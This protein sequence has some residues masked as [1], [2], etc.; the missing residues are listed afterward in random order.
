MAVGVGDGTVE[1]ALAAM[2]RRYVVTSRGIIA[3]LD[4][5][6]D[7]LQ[8]APASDD[9]LT[10]LRR[11]LHRVHG[12]AG[13]LGFTEASALAGAMEGLVRRWHDDPSLDRTRRS[14]IVLNFARALERAITSGGEGG[15]SD[16]RRL[17]LVGLDD[18]LAD[19][20][21]AEAM[22]RGLAVERAVDVASAGAPWAVIA[23]EEAVRATELADIGDAMC[24]VLRSGDA[25]GESWPSNV[26]VVDAAVAVADIVNALVEE[27]DG[28][29][30]TRGTVLIVDDD[31]MMLMLLG[32]LAES[33]GF[34]VVTAAGAS[35]FRDALAQGDL[36]LVVLDIELGDAS[37]IDLLRELRAHAVH[38][39]LPV[40]MLSGR[41]DSEARTAA[42]EAGSDDYMLKPVVP[43]EFQQRLERL[44]DVGRA[45]QS[46]VAEEASASSAEVAPDVVV[47]EDDPALRE[48][49]AFAL[50]ARGLTHRAYASGPEALA[51]LLAMEPGNRSTIVLLDIDL[52]GMDGHS[53]HERLRVERPG[54]F[55]VVFI[56]LHTGEADQLRALKGGAL[57]YLIKP[58]SLRVLI[59]KLD[60]WR[61]RL[62]AG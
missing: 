24:I 42:F 46:S 62:M 61:E 37:G 52:P 44:A 19:E 60:V 51:A 26:N 36:S 58:I 23:A 41:S 27:T 35:E 2:R 4:L 11:E 5:V 17:V 30:A 45:R 25:S 53:L 7:G 57:D 40:L 14:T 32:A 38:A 31:P 3:T 22:H 28:T 54:A 56:S 20:F 43:P 9:L 13:S 48:M 47:V 12:T 29:G 55:H 39:R 50:D 6:G 59:A 10:L 15:S 8:G 18:T 49:L 21:V 16:G 1:T 34:N 33:D